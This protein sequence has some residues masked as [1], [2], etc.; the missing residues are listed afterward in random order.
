M[1]EDLRAPLLRAAKYIMANLRHHSPSAESA[2]A[3]HI[4][5]RGDGSA[6]IINSDVGAWATQT[7]ARHPL[8]AGP[9]NP[10]GWDHWYNTNQKHPGRTHWATRAVDE[11]IDTAVDKFGDEYIKELEVEIQ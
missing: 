3:W 4:T 11:A 9:R 1:S 6:H 2:E 8:F 5:E 7:N 10:S